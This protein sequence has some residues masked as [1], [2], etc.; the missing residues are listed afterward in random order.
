MSGLGYNTLFSDIER[1]KAAKEKQKLLE[2][3]Y[4]KD[5]KQ[6]ESDM[7]R[8]PR[9]LQAHQ[10][11]V[12]KCAGMTRAEW[13]STFGGPDCQPIPSSPTK[14][15]KPTPPP[16]SRGGYKKARKA[17]YSRKSKYSRKAR[18]SRKAKYSRNNK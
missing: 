9:R 11:Y 1:E 13:M 7:E 14:P 3:L 15:I 6:Y 10:E 12:A 4:Q 2:E 16:T 18:Y 5:L 17:R 8:Y